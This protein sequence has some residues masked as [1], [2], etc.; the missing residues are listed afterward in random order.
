MASDDDKIPVVRANSSLGVIRRCSGKLLDLVIKHGIP[1][2]QSTSELLAAHKGR[3]D[4]VEAIKT[5]FIEEGRVAAQTKSELIKMAAAATD[6]VQ[7]QQILLMVSQVDEQIRTIKV[8]EKSLSYIAESTSTALLIDKTQSEKEDSVKDEKTEFTHL[9]VI[10]DQWLDTFLNYARMR[11]EPWREDLLARLLAKELTNPGSM[12]HQVIWAI[13]NLTEQ[14]FNR[15][16]AVL[17]IVVWEND[18]ETFLLPYVESGCSIVDE[19]IISDVMA[20]DKDYGHLMPALTEA[21]FFHQ[22]SPVGGS[23]QRRY[24]KNEKTKFRYGE[25][26][27]EGIWADDFIYKA[28]LPTQLGEAVASLYVPKPNHLGE[29]LF[30]KWVSRLKMFEVVKSPTP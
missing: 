29:S 9:E 24:S 12:N 23:V 1:L 6:P 3:L 21:G 22:T 13:G 19:K 25:K 5:V 30:Y 7:K 8:G 18:N 20:S 28:L 16:A 15:Y 17:D 26:S 14:L 11:N 2:A 10:Q 4:S 27:V